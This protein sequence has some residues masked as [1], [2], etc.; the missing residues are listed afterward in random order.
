MI[1]GGPSNN[2]KDAFRGLQGVMNP[3]PKGRSKE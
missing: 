1:N 2:D 3:K